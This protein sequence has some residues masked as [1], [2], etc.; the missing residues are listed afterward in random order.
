MFFSGCFLGDLVKKFIWL[1]ISLSVIAAV[2]I[3]GE[4]LFNYALRA[5]LELHGIAG[6]QVQ[7]EGSTIF[8]F[9]GGKENEEILI[10]LHGVGG[11]ALTSW[12]G[13]M[14]N[15]VRHY[16]V[17]APD[18]FFANLPDLV[19]SGYHIRMEEQLV[20]MLFD[21]LGIGQASLVGLSFGAWPALRFAAEHPQRV[22]RIALI[23][24][25]PGSAFEIFSMLDLDEK[26]PGKDFYFRIFE[27]PP[28]IPNFFLHR[29]WDRTTVLFNSLPYFREQ[30]ENE[31][32]MVSEMFSN[33]TCPVLIVHGNDDRII[34]AKL[35]QQMAA[36]LP[37][38]STVGLEKC[39]HAVV[40]DRSKSLEQIV[41]KYFAQEVSL[42]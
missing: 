22:K 27:F 40:W 39:G 38:G 30:L 3:R 25:L 9:E 4:N 17:L 1:L 11:N 16:H 26:N 14:P 15:L 12:F 31:G 28:P 10:L 36:A 19:G 42:H 32:E 23:S 5:Y 2:V 13:I 18:M 29:H 20:A 35:F 24:P 8:Y 21:H 41:E 37:I 7:I 6:E 34:Q 33:V